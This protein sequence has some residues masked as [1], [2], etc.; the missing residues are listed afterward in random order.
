[1]SFTARTACWTMPSSAYASEPRGSLSDGMPNRSTP[2][3]PMPA[4][5]LHS[6][7][8]SSTEKRC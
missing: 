4:A 1:M 6:L 7:T 5:S 8:S 2:G 3:M